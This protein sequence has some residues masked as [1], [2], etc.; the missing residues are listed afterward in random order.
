[1]LLSESMINELKREF[2]GMISQQIFYYLH[3][4]YL[5]LK[6]LAILELTTAIQTKSVFS[7]LKLQ[8]NLF[9]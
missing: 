5:T 3:L 6:T 8:T 4:M 7:V 9:S 1:M 2:I